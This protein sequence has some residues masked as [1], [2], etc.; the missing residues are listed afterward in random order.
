MLPQVCGLACLAYLCMSFRLG[1]VRSRGRDLY[2]ARFID[3]WVIRLYLYD[4]IK[5][6]YT[7]CTT[8]LRELHRLVG[9][10]KR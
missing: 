8:V 7:D 3:W 5:T 6:A 4:W 2:Y 9:H 10:I 1:V